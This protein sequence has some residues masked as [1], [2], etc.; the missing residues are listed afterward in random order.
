MPMF[1]EMPQLTVAL[2]RDAPA[3]QL[4]D[5]IN[6][7]TTARELR[8]RLSTLRAKRLDHVRFELRINSFK[9]V[10]LSSL[11]RPTRVAAMD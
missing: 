2:D 5:D 7:E 6:P 8:H 10:R 11:S 3:I 9:T 4:G 1:V